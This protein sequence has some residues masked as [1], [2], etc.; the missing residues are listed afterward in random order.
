MFP[1]AFQFR[2]IM[3]FR[4]LMEEIFKEACNGR[5]AFAIKFQ[6]SKISFWENEMPLLE[7][8]K[9]GSNRSPGRNTAMCDAA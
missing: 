5:K 4:Y 9:A 7:T 2:I 8:S 3:S 6:A 1:Y